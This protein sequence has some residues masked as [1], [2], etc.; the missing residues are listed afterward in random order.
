MSKATGVFVAPI[1]G[2]T[3]QQAPEVAEDDRPWTESI[4]GP[5]KYPTWWLRCRLGEQN[6]HY[7]EVEVHEREQVPGSAPDAVDWS[8]LVSG[9]VKWDGCANL[10]FHTDECLAHFCGWDG[11]CEFHDVMREVF[12]LAMLVMDDTAR[13]DLFGLTEGE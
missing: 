2:A 9:H 5:E 12:R 4:I 10:R 13:P 7:A 6:N 8:L 3:V 11:W 1:D